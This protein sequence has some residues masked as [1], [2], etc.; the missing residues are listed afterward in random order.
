MEKKL[1]KDA[2]KGIK[3]LDELED[4][5]MGFWEEQ[6]DN[7]AKLKDLFVALSITQKGLTTN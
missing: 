6:L 3:S 1:N 5:L 4:F 7:K 2:L